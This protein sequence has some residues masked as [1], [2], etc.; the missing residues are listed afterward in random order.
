[1]ERIAPGGG[2]GPI[3]PGGGLGPD[4]GD[5]RH[6]GQASVMSGLKFWTLPV[7]HFAPLDAVV[8]GNDAHER[9]SRGSVRQSE[10]RPPAGVSRI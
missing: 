10:T 8:F 3:A 9:E 2:L 1:M 5:R 4:P 6:W 7:N